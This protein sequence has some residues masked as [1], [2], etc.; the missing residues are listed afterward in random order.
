[1]VQ[2]QPLKPE[3]NQLW[4]H[5][6]PLEVYS[7]N[8]TRCL[9][10]IHQ[11]ASEVAL[12]H[13]QSG[14]KERLAFDVRKIDSNLYCITKRTINN[15]A[16]VMDPIKMAIKRCHGKK[17]YD[18]RLDA[19]LSVAAARKKFVSEKLPNQAYQCS[20]CNFWH[21]GRDKKR[22]LHNPSD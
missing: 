13:R 7:I 3:Y 1:M 8:S 17:K 16:I 20:V 15:E 2:R 6:E 9:A 18:T 22:L 11:R 19:L 12:E 21:V 5:S 14:S 4:E 10:R